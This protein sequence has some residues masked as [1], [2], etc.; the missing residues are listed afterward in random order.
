MATQ[1]QIMVGL[2]LPAPLTG[3][4]MTFTGSPLLSVGATQSLYYNFST[5]AY[6]T[7]SCVLVGATGNGTTGFTPVFLPM[8]TGITLTVYPA[9]TNT[10]TT[11]S[12]LTPTPAITYTPTPTPT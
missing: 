2:A 3:T 10:L 5:S 9:T 8:G 12:T 7:I 1:T 11:T 4:T 6:G